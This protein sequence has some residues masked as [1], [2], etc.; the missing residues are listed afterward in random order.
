MTITRMKERRYSPRL[1][2]LTSVTPQEQK[3]WH[4]KQRIPQSVSYWWWKKSCT[5]WYGKYSIYL[6]GFIHV[7]WSKISSINNIMSKVITKNKS[8]FHAF[9]PVM[10]VLHSLLTKP[11]NLKSNLR[12]KSQKNEKMWTPTSTFGQLLL[13]FLHHST[14]HQTSRPFKGHLCSLWRCQTH[15]SVENECWKPKWSSTPLRGSTSSPPRNP[16]K[17]RTY[18]ETQRVS[19]GFFCL[20]PSRASWIASSS[21]GVGF[22]RSHKDGNVCS[23]RLGSKKSFGFHGFVAKCRP[24]FKKKRKNKRMVGRK[25]DH[26]GNSC[27]RRHDVFL[28]FLEKPWGSP[29]HSGIRR[30]S[31]TLFRKAGWKLVVRYRIIR[32]IVEILNLLGILGF[33]SI[34]PGKQVAVNFHQLLPLTP[35][36]VASNY[37]TLC[38]PGRNI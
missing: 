28:Y 23:L 16:G 18:P 21:G 25:C 34:I 15:A 4:H 29:Y 12:C 2:E 32:E 35:A 6:Q 13:S 19:A 22:L 3:T 38:F 36:T 24:A 27:Q 17:P 7:R 8:N 37:G 11:C 1:S 20:W 5:R 14:N 30:P 10:N 31:K 9:R 33:W 26:P